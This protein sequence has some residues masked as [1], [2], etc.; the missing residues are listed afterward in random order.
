LPGILTVQGDYTQGAGGAFDELLA[1][2]VVGTGYSQLDVK[3]PGGAA[4]LAGALDG[5][6]GTG[7]GLALVDTFTIMQFV[8]SSGTFGLFALNSRS[9]SAS[10]SD[11]WN[12][13]TRTADVQ[14]TEIFGSTFINL[15]VT[16]FA[17]VPEPSTWAMLGLGFAGLGF[18]GY[19]SREAA[20]A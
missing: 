7:F 17:P 10:V 5:T 11:V 6:T 20:A 4:S 12:C 18:L 19:R 16:A 13:V 14:F 8:D 1:R 15:Q 9:C 3:S 2:L